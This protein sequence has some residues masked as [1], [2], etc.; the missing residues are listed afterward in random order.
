MS[1][2]EFTKQE[3]NA[4]SESI[5][6]SL[7]TSL[8][9]FGIWYYVQLH[10]IENFIAD[11]GFFIFFAILSYVLIL[12]SEK[13]VRAYKEFPCMS[14][15]MIGMTVGMISGF[16]SGFF[17]GATNAKLDKKVSYISFQ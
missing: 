6:I 15:M 1:L 16:L 7:L 5:I 3:K 12:P 9:T 2:H 11:Y 13:T 8:I 17:V 14:G 4:V 10:S